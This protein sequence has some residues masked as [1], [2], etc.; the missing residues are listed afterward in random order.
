MTTLSEKQ[1][2]KERRKENTEIMEGVNEDGRG[3]E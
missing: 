3:E 2:E 1:L